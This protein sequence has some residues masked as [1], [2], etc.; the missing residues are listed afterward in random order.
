MPRTASPHDSARALPFIAAGVLL[1]LVVL[2]LIAVA[3]RGL[4]EFAAAVAG[5]EVRSAVTLTAWTSAVALLSIVILGTP[6]AWL[7]AR[8]RSPAWRV[9]DAIIDLPIAL[10]PAVA[11]LGL[12]LAFGRNGL[13]APLLQPL[14]IQLSFSTAAVVVA[15][16]FV[17]AP[18]YVRAAVAGFRSV[19]QDLERVA[20]VEGA[21]P[22]QIFRFVT[23]PLALPSL[24]AGAVTA[25]A[26]S[27][28]EF[29]ATIFFAGNL[30]GRTQTMALAIYSSFQSD[31]PAALAL[32]LL[33]LLTS[34]AVLFA[35]RR[36]H[37]QS[38][39]G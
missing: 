38:D 21:D 4:P 36:L 18:L 3:V 12:L 8:R 16:V 25:W 31:L 30:P 6:T 23:L 28:G 14:G 34:L 11:G 5:A 1:S 24:A 26:R 22:W 15:Q 29:G 7:I 17:A 20:M 19:D 37:T 2:P 39:H 27:L 32:T 35:A 13:L 33:L 9:I 10:P